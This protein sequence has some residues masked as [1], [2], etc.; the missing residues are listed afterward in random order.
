VFEGVKGVVAI[1]ETFIFHIILDITFSTL[2][3]GYKSP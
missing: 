1:F 3:F 2:A